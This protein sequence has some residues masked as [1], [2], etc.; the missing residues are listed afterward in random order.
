M[1]TDSVWV[2]TEF[3]DYEGQELPEVVLGS[4]DVDM[5]KMFY[6]D[7]DWRRAGDR[8]AANLPE[9]VGGLDPTSHRVLISKAPLVG[10]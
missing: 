8:W 10:A 9:G 3:T 6:G 7:A 4:V 2:A 1:D 5:V